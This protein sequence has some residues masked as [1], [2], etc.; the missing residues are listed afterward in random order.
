MECKVAK[1]ECTIDCTGDVCCGDTILFTEKVFGGS[2]RKPVYRGERWIYAEVIADSYGA[3][4]QQH[5]LTLKLVECGGEGAEEVCAIAAR[6]QGTIRR[7]AR[8]VYANGTYRLPWAD[9]EA[10]EKV[11]EEK[12]RRGAVARAERSV[13]REEELKYGW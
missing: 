10:R 11:L 5:T 7:K 1:P 12:Y 8:N 4:K 9:E 6:N 13:R 2:Y 3:A